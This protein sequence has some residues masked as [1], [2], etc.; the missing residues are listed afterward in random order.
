MILFARP[1][2]PYRYAN[3]LPSHSQIPLKRNT[4]TNPYESP[5]IT[6]AERFTSV[7]LILLLKLAGLLLVA[8]IAGAVCNVMLQILLNFILGGMV[9]RGGLF[10]AV[11][12]LVKG[13]LP[14]AIQ[15][16]ATLAI[17]RQ[18]ARIQVTAGLIAGFL[19]LGSAG[20]IACCAYSLPGPG[21]GL[22]YMSIGVLFGACAGTAFYVTEF[23]KPRMGM[24]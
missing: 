11:Y 10:L 13:A 19:L 17:P 3:K 15:M 22:H 16:V 18:N 14:S 7:S 2:K 9:A 12:F 21:W 20:Y 24:A 23:L 6:S 5:T 1:P 4:L 8:L